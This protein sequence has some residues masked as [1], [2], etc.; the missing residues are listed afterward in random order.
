MLALAPVDLMNN[1][2]ADNCEHIKHKKHHSGQ[3][4]ILGQVRS[5]G[6]LYIWW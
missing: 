3:S 2:W 5:Q 1:A 6:Y 4:T